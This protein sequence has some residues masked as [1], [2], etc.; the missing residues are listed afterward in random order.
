[1]ISGGLTWTRPLRLGG[2][3]V[4]SDFAMRPDLITFPTPAVRV[5]TAVPSTVDVFVN[6]ISRLSRRVEP[7]PFEVD[8]LPFVTGGGDVTVVVRDALGRETVQF[9]P[10]Y[11]SSSRLLPGLSSYSIEAGEVR[12]D[13]G[14]KSNDYGEATGSATLRH[15]FTDWLTGEAH[16]EGSGKVATGG[17]G[18]AIQVGS[19]GVLSALAGSGANSGIGT[20][21]A[22]GF[23]HHSPHFSVGGSI[24]LADNRFRDV[25]SQLTDAAPL[26]SHASASA[27][28]SAV[29]VRSPFPI[30]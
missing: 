15:G 26:R 5:E 8:G 29:P 3:Q 21:V 22:L 27:C 17:V 10:F 28:R 20:Q 1:V 14:F 18:T 25:A 19:I 2:A 4:A 30:R 11:A 23:E 9:L 6:N 13:Y 7:G 24:I 12:E 16:V